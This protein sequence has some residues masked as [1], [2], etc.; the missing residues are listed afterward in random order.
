MW[1][2]QWPNA[3]VAVATGAGSG[4]IAI[5]IDGPEGEKS[6][7]GKDL[8]PAFEQLTGGGGRHLVYA[9]PGNCTLKSGAGLLHK[10]DSRAEGGY[11]MVQPSNH[12]SGDFYE[13][14]TPP[15]DD[16]PTCAPDW[17]LDLL[18]ER[19][20]KPSSIHAPSQVQEGG[21]N[22]YLAQFA[23]KLRRS[24]HEYD[25]MLS[26]I[27]Y[28]NAKTCKPPLEEDEVE[29]ICRSIAGYAIFTPEEEELIARGDKIAKIL[30]D[31]M[32]KERLEALRNPKKVVLKKP[33][34][35]KDFIPSSGLIREVYDWIINTSRYPLPYLAMA[36]SVSFVST[37]IG[38]KVKTHTGI[39]PNVYMIGLADSGSGKDHAR[40]CI[41][42]LIT[43]C[44]LNHI[45]GG[46]KIA[47]GAGLV[48]AVEES[49]VKLYQLDEIGLML[50]VLFDRNAGG[51]KKELAELMMELFTT[52][53]YKGTDYADRKLKKPAII[54][55]PFI[56]IYGT[57]TP[58]EFYKALQSGSSSS[59]FLNRMLFIADEKR[60]K[61][62]DRIPDA[63]PATLIESV[64][65]FYKSIHGEL[66]S[67]LT[68]SHLPVSYRFSCPTDIDDSWN[69]FED[70]LA[71]QEYDY[72]MKDIYSRVPAH[73]MKLATIFSLSRGSTYVQHDDYAMAREI[74]IWST[75]VIVEGMI[76]H[77][78][79]NETER[80]AKKVASIIR[81][82][83]HGITRSEIIHK[84]RWLQK[85]E[86]DQILQD[87]LDSGKISVL[88]EDSGGPKPITKIFWEDD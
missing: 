51:H 37:L 50:Q 71:A 75:A 58:S 77:V 34:P 59:G 14:K 45:M 15:W 32:E 42:S 48:A 24:G 11:I 69:D 18:V 66:D 4:I 44:G 38:R 47:S 40:G 79:D 60:E 67:N 61:C 76:Q 65:N 17:W 49:P 81:L 12:K 86:R 21:R 46:S 22:N 68:G 72:G 23:G 39:R 56:S 36:A 26:I 19:K 9:H 62:R 41:S 74:V 5:D 84:T 85:F 55:E 28:H 83:V 3:N 57:S 70:A 13:W 52:K 16:Y 30:I 78:A 88:Q 35:P 63:P 7:E 87:L 82:A 31:N 10:V 29:R 8:P 53:E 27:Q 33:V 1:W 6:L 54:I 73:V 64:K 43:A 2:Q 25:E 20:P 80:K